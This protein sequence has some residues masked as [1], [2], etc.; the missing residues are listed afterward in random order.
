M[1]RKIFKWAGVD[2]DRWKCRMFHAGY[3]Y[4]EK[5]WRCNKCMRIY[6]KRLSDGDTG[7]R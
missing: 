5:H 1:I 6:R 7:P 4:D 2:Y 3:H